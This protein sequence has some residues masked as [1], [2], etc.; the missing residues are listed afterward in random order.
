[1]DCKEKK[2]KLRVKGRE[3]KAAKILKMIREID[4]IT[5]ELIENSYN[6]LDED[7]E[8]AQYR[9]VAL[10]NIKQEISALKES[11]LM[12][13]DARKIINGKNEDKKRKICKN[14]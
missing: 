4:E 12:Y 5:D 9:G 3:R 10:T 1:M 2:R 7:I 14:K 6:C 13:I 11:L 8:T